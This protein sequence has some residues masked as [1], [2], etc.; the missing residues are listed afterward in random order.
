MDMQLHHLARL[1]AAV[2]AGAAIGL[3]RELHAKPAG[4]RTN[5][6]ICLGAALFTLLSIEMAEPPG[7]AAVD[8][9]R[10][11]AQVVTGVGFLGAGAIIRHRGSVIGLTTAATIWTV[12][13]IGMAFGAGAYLLGAAST[14]LAAGVLF[15][16]SAVEA[17]I[18]GLRTTARLQFRLR[19]PL[20]VSETLRRFVQ[21]SGARCRTW[22]VT[23]QE[24]GYSVYAKLVGARDQLERV[25]RALIARDEVLSLTR[26]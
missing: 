26:L 17:R 11:A 15:T 12:A 6:L 22:K 1:L 23:K 20:E 3:E 2:A 4:F 18:A 25:Q 7:P 13:S 8:R 16:L 5:I 19:G 9:T 10:I 21:D 24:E 14:I